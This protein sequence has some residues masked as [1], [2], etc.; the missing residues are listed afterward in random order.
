M[1]LEIGYAVAQMNDE[2]F[3]RRDEGP[4]TLASTGA[5]RLL[6]SN[7]PNPEVAKAYQAVPASKALLFTLTHGDVPIFELALMKNFERIP[8]PVKTY[9]VQDKDTLGSIARRL[10]GS[11]N[12]WPTI[13]AINRQVVE[14]PKRLTIGMELSVPEEVDSWVAQSDQNSKTAPD[15]EMEQSQ[16]A[17]ADYVKR[18]CSNFPELAR[19]K[20]CQVP[21][22]K[23]NVWMDAPVA[24][25]SR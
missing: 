3:S 8:Y 24:T 22:F 5:D 21:S 25:T 20:G 19:E 7:H 6:F 4:I 1:L 16:K 18:A 17:L 13:W 9:K 10:T 12:N 14:D 15:S 2:E 11:Y 23:S